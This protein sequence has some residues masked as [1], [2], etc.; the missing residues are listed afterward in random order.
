[1]RDE[2]SNIKVTGAI[3]L[4]I[5][6][7]GC[8]TTSDAESRYIKGWRSGEILQIGD[9]ATQ[10]PIA[11]ID[12]RRAGLLPATSAAQR[13]AYVEFVFAQTGGKYFYSGPPQR[14]AL[15]SIPEG[16]EFKIGERVSVNIRDCLLPLQHSTL[17]AHVVV[18][19]L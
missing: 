3:V 9:A 18:A 4:L 11:S 7:A 2:C 8:V 19:P 17:D 1:M 15:V 13:Y 10:F 6:L 14:H 5:L 12:C 16:S